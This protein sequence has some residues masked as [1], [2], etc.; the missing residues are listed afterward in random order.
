MALLD[1]NTFGDNIYKRFPLKYR[2][3]DATNGYALKRF[4]SVASEGGFKNV[5]DDINSLLRVI[6]PSTSTLEELFILYEQYGLEVFNGIPEGYLRRLLPFI[7]DA[8]SFKG[9]LSVIDFL[10]TSVT[11]LQTETTIETDNEDNSVDVEVAL[12]LTSVAL[13]YF[14]NYDQFIRILKNFIPFYCTLYVVY[15]YYYTEGDDIFHFYVGHAIKEIAE[16]Y[17]NNIGE[18]DDP[19]AGHDFYGS[20]EDVYATENNELLIE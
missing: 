8:C 13:K 18:I 10:A 9:S 14:P 2:L 17:P 5:I 4:I 16:I 3:D 19:V 12:N 6:S 11:G 20:D 15:N 1:S 7:H